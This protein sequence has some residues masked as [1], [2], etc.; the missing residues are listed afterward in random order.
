MSDTKNALLKI[1]KT[2]RRWV[3]DY[4]VTTEF[5]LGDRYQKPSTLE[6][7]LRELRLSGAIN[8]GKISER[9]GGRKVLL[10]RYRRA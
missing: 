8:G 9:R 6:R 5:N 1:V 4:E 2:A 10:T 7:R 3:Y